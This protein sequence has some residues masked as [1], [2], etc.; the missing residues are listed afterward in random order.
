M[1]YVSFSAKLLISYFNKNRLNSFLLSLQI[2]YLRF[3]S[4]VKI[5]RYCT[6]E[7]CVISPW[8]FESYVKISRYCTRND[9]YLPYCLFESYVKI[10]RYCTDRL[11]DGQ[12]N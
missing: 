4:Y 5:S 9:E 10:S 7:L 11:R 12:Y 1:T 6:K 2:S 3:E 8:Q